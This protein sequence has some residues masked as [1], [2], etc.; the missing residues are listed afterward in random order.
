MRKGEFLEIG[1]TMVVC[2]DDGLLRDKD[3]TIYGVASLDDSLDD[4]V[5]LGVWPFALSK[6][7]PLNDAAKAHDAAY[8]IPAFQRH[9]YRSVADAKLEEDLFLLA[10][11]S[12]YERAKAFALAKL[13][14]VFG[15]WFWENRGTR[16]R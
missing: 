8:S 9:N 16:G 7:D 5:R 10:G 3:G 12:P 6:N 4:E 13:A 2:G 11:R 1:G 14:R 15:G